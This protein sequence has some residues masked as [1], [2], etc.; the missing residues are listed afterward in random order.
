M[1]NSK[2]AVS[3]IIPVYNTELYF[4]RTI[5]AVANQTLKNIEIVVV[6]DCS[7]GNIESIINEYI[8]HDSRIKYCK[9]PKNVGVGGAR[10][11]GLQHATGEYIMFCDSDDW[12]DLCTLEAMYHAGNRENADIVNCSFYRDYNNGE[13][14]WDCYY[15]TDYVV[16]GKTALKMLA[17][18]YDYGVELCVSTTNKIYRHQLIQDISF[19][20]NVCYEEALFNFCAIQKSAIVAFVKTGKYTYYK[21]FGSNLQSMTMKHIDDYNKVFS[22]IKLQIDIDGKSKVLKHTF[23]AYAE[24]FMNIIIEQIYE[25]QEGE[26]IRKRYIMSLLEVFDSLVSLEDYIDFLGIERFRWNLQPIMMHNSQRLL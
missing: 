11:L 13:K 17:H 19:M 5:G 8:N 4:D 2:V 6:N 9:T 15:S 10:N 12:L 23:I 3:V 22:K 21:R 20:E 1:D 24:Y 7:F 16:N 18:Q 14:K 25:S 26:E